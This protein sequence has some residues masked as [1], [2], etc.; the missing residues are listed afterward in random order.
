M[1][2]KDLVRQW[3]DEE[4]QLTNMQPLA[5]SPAGLIELSDEELIGVDAGTTPVC[6]TLVSIITVVISTGFSCVTCTC[7]S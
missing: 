4:F 6:I 2:N 7:P 3:K 5:A 1:T